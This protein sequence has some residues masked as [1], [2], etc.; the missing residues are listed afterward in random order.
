[1]PLLFS[2]MDSVAYFVVTQGRGLPLPAAQCCKFG[3][4]N[5]KRYAPVGADDPVRPAGRTCKYGRANA[6]PYN[7]SQLP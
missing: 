4:T 2:F 6:N 1:M 5:A 7:A 3:C